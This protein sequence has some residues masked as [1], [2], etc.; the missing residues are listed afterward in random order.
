MH[1]GPSDGFLKVMNSASAVFITGVNVFCPL[2][3]EL[4]V[5]LYHGEASVCLCY[6]AVPCSR[7]N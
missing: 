2:G 6:H 1:K 4:C 3:S 5:I 7:T